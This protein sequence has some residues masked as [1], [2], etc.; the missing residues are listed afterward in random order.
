MSEVGASATGLRSR[1]FR[2]LLASWGASSIGDGVLTAALP[3]FTAVS[4][5]DPLSVS[6]VAVAS[7]LP[8]LVVAL[9][10]GALVDRWSPRTTLI[11]SLVVRSGLTLSLGVL[12]MLGSANV[13]VLAVSAFMLSSAET[14]ADSAGQKLLVALAGRS[15]LERANGRVVSAETAGV[16]IAGPLAAAGLF[17]W[18]PEF[19]FLAVG[20]TFVVAGLLAAT[21]SVR[22]E[23]PAKRETTAL[24]TEVLEG[25]RFLVRQRTLR[26]VVGVVGLTAFLTSGVNAV[27]FLYAIESL[28]LPVASVATLLVCTAVGALAAAPLAS[29]LALRW[30]SG[31]VMICALFVLAVGIATLGVGRS[32]WAAWVAYLVMGVGAGAWNVLSSA[33]RQRLTP[34]PLMGRVT[35]AHRVLAWGLMPLGAALAGPVAAMTSLRAVIIGA[36]VVVM[37]IA[38]LSAPRLLGVAQAMGRAEVEEVVE[39]SPG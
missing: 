14:F 5:R 15:E 16:E 38:L 36:A 27:A 4:T 19:C 12:I 39:S 6:I 23:R 17:A 2:V 22:V 1:A 10:A 28:H 34:P 21:V 7:V 13:A 24:R 32:Q 26:V 35:S 33:N 18:K 30:G 25:L 37:A 9:L 29:K 11:V 8:W 20:V 31:R 3:L